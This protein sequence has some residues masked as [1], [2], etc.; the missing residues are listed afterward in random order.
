MHPASW[1]LAPV[2][3]AA[4]VALA[5]CTH[6][7]P[8][9]DAGAIQDK[10]AQCAAVPSSNGGPWLVGTVFSPA[11]ADV[12][13][14]IAPEVTYPIQP[15]PGAS[16]CVAVAPSQYSPLITT[17]SYPGTPS[18]TPASSWPEAPAGTTSFVAV[19]PF[20]VVNVTDCATGALMYSFSVFGETAATG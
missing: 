13:A 15:N 5:A 10:A 2:I 8:T 3:A 14:A 16:A 9:A 1:H 17:V 12:E 4:A 19:T 18:I 7:T 6:T 11:C 20:V